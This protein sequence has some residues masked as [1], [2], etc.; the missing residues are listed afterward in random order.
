M[1]LNLNKELKN[2]I[3]TALTYVD[4][5]ASKAIGHDA[6]LISKIY[7]DTE[8]KSVSTDP[9]PE[10]YP[11]LNA[12]WIAMKTIHPEITFEQAVDVVRVKIKGWKEHSIK[13][14]AER[15]TATIQIINAKHGSDI[16]KILKNLSFD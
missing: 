14:H 2:Q 4:Q 11:W 12:E 3:S 7:C 8:L 1:R 16:S 10:D 5:A 15:M 6:D 13:I 9:S